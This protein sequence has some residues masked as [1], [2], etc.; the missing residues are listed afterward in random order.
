MSNYIID[1]AWVYYVKTVGWFKPLSV[2]VLIL[3]AIAAVIFFVGYISETE[4]GGSEE[5]AKHLKRAL[6]ICAVIS[7]FSVCGIVFFPSTETLVEMKIAELATKDNIRIS[8]E[9]AKKIA[10]YIINAIQMMR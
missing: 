8:F 4:Y 3:T 9:E 5:T 7:F 1:P 6:K 10:D 2:I